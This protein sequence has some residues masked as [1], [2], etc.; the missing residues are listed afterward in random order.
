M[1]DGRPEILVAHVERMLTTAL[2][3][4]HDAD[5][6]SESLEAA[7][8]SAYLLRLLALEI[9]L[10]ALLLTSGVRAMR[11]H[12]YD[13]LF[14]HLPDAIQSRILAQA[15]ERMSTSADYST[16]LML[17]ETFSDNFI[18]LRYPYE[19]HE[20]ES[21]AEFTEL[22]RKWLDDG[23]LDADASVLYHP[24]ELQGFNF[25]LQSEVESWIASA[26]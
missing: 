20:R 22:G 1:S 7:S 9:L 15:A 14:S 25:A 10:K 12:R 17:L 2:A 16:H 8:D 18:D 3:R 5:L 26:S 23:A 24:L 4:L 13:S 6:L 11:S 19:G 21:A